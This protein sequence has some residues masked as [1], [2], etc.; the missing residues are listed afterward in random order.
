MG[1]TLDL[2]PI[3]A[4]VVEDQ[5]SLTVAFL[6]P[7]SRPALDFQICKDPSEQDVQMGMDSVYLGLTETGIGGYDIVEELKLVAGGAI[8]VAL[9]V[10]GQTFLGLPKNVCLHFVR[11]KNS[12]V[13]EKALQ[14]VVAHHG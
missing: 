6:F 1:E 8:M 14:T 12:D 13:I 4:E 7:S 9:N 3:R 11:L 2:H 10:K 5:Y